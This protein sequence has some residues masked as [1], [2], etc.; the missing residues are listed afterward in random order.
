MKMKDNYE[1]DDKIFEGL[2]YHLGKIQSEKA[3]DFLDQMDASV[4]EMDYPEELND[5]FNTYL[6]DQEREKVKVLKKKRI[7][8]LSKWVALFLVVLTAGFSATVFSVEAFKIKWFNMVSDM[9]NKYTEIKFV[10]KE[11]AEASAVNITWDAYLYP[12]YLPQEFAL[13]SFQTLG[14]TKLVYFADASGNQIEFSQSMDSAVYQ[15]DTEQAES[16]KIEVQG[17]EGLL[18]RKAGFSTL[19][20]KRGDLT[21]YLMGKLPD[22]ELVKIAESIRLVK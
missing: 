8:T 13:E 12:D 6:K 22:Q 9:T 14:N 5:W 17:S 18:I 15:V 7:G 2:Y 4:L 21:L 16:A 19:V 10:E 1:D 20:W 11:N 3:G